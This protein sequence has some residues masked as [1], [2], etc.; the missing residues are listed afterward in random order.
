[1][2]NGML[3]YPALLDNMNCKLILIVGQE[4]P[5]RCYIAIYASINRLLLLPLRSI[6]VL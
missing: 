2:V 4:C 5:A 3:L 6:M 1:M